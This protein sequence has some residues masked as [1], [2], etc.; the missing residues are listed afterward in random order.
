MNGCLGNLLIITIRF[1]WKIINFKCVNL[2]TK[3]LGA[4]IKRSFGPGVTFFWILAVPFNM[5]AA[6]TPADQVAK[7]TIINSISKSNWFLCWWPSWWILQAPGTCEADGLC[8]DGSMIQTEL[9]DKEEKHVCQECEESLEE[10]MI[11]AGFHPGAGAEGPHDDFLNN[12]TACGDMD[13][14]CWDKCFEKAFYNSK[15]FRKQ[16]E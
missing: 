6:A 7:Q 10:C 4:F 2:T 3:T 16:P 1:E 12:R 15:A 11:K 5:F 8:P 13:S 14:D 9:E